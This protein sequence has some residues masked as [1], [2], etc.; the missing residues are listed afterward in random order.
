MYDYIKGTLVKVEPTNAVI[1]AG[2]I[3]YKLL[4]PL[5]VYSDV[6]SMLGKP[7]LLYCSFVVREDSQR[8]F[9]FLKESS[10]DLFITLSDVSGI[11]PK[12][13]L[14]ILGHMSIDELKLAL[15]HADALSLVKVPGIGKKTAE[16]LILELRDKISKPSQD[17]MS[18]LGKGEDHMFHDAVSAL[19]HLGYQRAAAQNAVKKALEKNVKSLSELISKSLKCT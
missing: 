7:L 3:G 18:H 9:G 5:N 2:G 19:M 4:I 11:G 16:R 15:H 17:G 10:R 14:S 8:L 1:D 12:T 13:A 6:S